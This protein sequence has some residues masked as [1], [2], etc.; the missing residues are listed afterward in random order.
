MKTGELMGKEVA[1]V[2]QI[3]PHMH[4]DFW[5]ILLKSLDNN[6]V[7]Q[8]VGM[9]ADIS[10]WKDP[11]GL[12]DDE[13]LVVKRCLG[14]FAGSESLVS[15]NLLL[16]IFRYITDPEAR[17]YI[18]RQSFEESIHN[19]TITYVCDSLDLKISE[20]YEAY[21]N[22]PAIKAKDDFL[23]EITSDI[24]RVGFDNSTD[25]Q[26]RE[27]IRNVVSY[28]IVCE[29]IFFFSGFAMLLNFNRVN[30]L[31]GLCKQIQYTLRDESLHIDFGVRLINKLRAQYPHLF[32]KQF[33]EDTIKH[34]KRAVEL[35][36]QY[37]KDVLPRGVMGLNSSMF[38]QYM[39]HIAN[40]RLASIGLAPQYEK[41]TNPF[42]W[43]NEAVELGK[44]GNYFETVEI[45]YKTGGSLK[46][47]F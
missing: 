11:K 44:M 34:I 19:L 18:S 17:M 41:T 36:V 15:N 45:S 4:K 40:H 13:R 39:K 37:A 24:S 14:F 23:L 32:T 16:N 2:N 25:E 7:P 42:P 5:E 35:E 26:K 12:T 27:F 6:W 1:G 46:D 9:Q 47:D 28:Y 31:P 3:L 38:I 20:V 43:L 30:K 33:D 8:H 29:G 21:I 10:T 22:I